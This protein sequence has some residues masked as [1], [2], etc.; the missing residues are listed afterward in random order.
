MN[1]GRPLK[2]TTAP[3][4]L[5]DLLALWNR[6]A[7]APLGI[8]IESQRPNALAQHL[9]AARREVGG[10]HDLRVVEDDGRV[11]IVPR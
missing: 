2:G 10:F 7:Q 1:R 11:W 6:A 4:L 8:V 9:Y 5:A 3:S